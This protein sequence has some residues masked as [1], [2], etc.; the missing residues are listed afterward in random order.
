MGVQARGHIVMTVNTSWNVYNFRRG[1][2]SALI[3]KGYH[4]TV[5]APDDHTTEKLSLLGCDTRHLEMNAKG[6]SVVGEAALLR[7]MRRHLKDLRPDAV[8]GFTIKN[9]LYGALAARTLDI[10]FIPTV[11][12]LGTAFLSGSTLQG[13]AQ[14]L[15]RL[16]F[17]RCPAVIFQNAAD[18]DL[19]LERGLV[20]PHQVAMSPGS[21]V[22]LDHFAPRPA[23]EVR[24]RTVFLFI[25]RMLA[26]KGVREL[27]EAARHIRARHPDCEFR[28]L[29]PMGKDNRSAIP[30]AEVRGWI[31]EGTITYLGPADDVRPH[32]ADADCVVLPSYREGSPRTLIEAAAMARPV[33]T[34]D[35]PGCR[36]VVDPGK[37]A[38]LC[39]VRD[40]VAL[41][42]AIEFFFSLPLDRQRAMGIAGRSL[43]QQSFDQRFVIKRYCDALD[44]AMAM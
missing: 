36:D 4:V 39:P 40:W 42:A 8:L 20:R 27:I 34:T 41:A 30:D 22:D 13:I 31:D 16:A 24:E 37:S 12:G 7:S 17:R 33:I 1:L 32:I 19:F 35:V 21:G 14:T 11:T 10:P 18:R 23:P 25:G 9:N 44:D 6:L 43:M 38:L 2:V 5:L 3:A 26:D 28:F 29:G 15:Y